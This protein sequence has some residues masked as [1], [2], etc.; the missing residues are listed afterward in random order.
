[1]ALSLLIL[2]AVDLVLIGLLPRIFFRQDGSFNLRWW[3]TALPFVAAGGVW[4]A[5]CVGWFVPLNLAGAGNVILAIGLPFLLQSAAMLLGLLALFLM[6][7]TL[8]THQRPLALWQQRNDAPEHLVRHGA[9]RFIRHPFY[10]AFL[11]V[12]AAL[13]LF[14]P[15]WITLAIFAYALVVLTLTARG[16]ERKFLHSPLADDYRDYMAAS[17]RFYPKGLWAAFVDVFGARK[18]N[19]ALKVE[20]GS[21]V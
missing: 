20:G 1:M 14:L 18:E 8:G 4:L 5:Y 6:G 15:H 2:L 7:Y 12:L 19:V 11:C 17:G 9:Y 10:S 16:E 21:H 13:L 3:L